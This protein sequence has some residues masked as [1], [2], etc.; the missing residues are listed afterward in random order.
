MKSKVIV[1][2]RL[3][4]FMGTDPRREKRAFGRTSADAASLNA[5]YWGEDNARRRHPIANPFPAGRRHDE[6]ERGMHIADPMGEHMGRN[7]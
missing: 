1:G 3:F 2:Y 6:F 4:S 5:F 7:A